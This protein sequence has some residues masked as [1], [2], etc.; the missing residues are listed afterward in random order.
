MKKQIKIILIV[1]TALIAAFGAVSLI[2]YYTA[3][4]PYDRYVD[5]LE[6]HYSVNQIDSFR[7]YAEDEAGYSYYIKRPDFWSWSGNLSVSI[8]VFQLGSGDEM[9]Y[10]DGLLLWPKGDSCELG[11][12]LY[13]Y[14][15]DERGVTANGVQLYLDGEGNYLPDGTADEEGQAVLD[16]HRENVDVLLEKLYQTW[17]QFAP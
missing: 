11:V 14:S 12:M 5:Q 9:P 10:V 17:P 13:E 7:S 3:F 16:R 2:W 4:R 15:E 1:L 8:P 6:E